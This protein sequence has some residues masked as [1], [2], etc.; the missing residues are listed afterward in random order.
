MEKMFTK[1]NFK[2]IVLVFLLSAFVMM[3]IHNIKMDVYIKYFIIPIM[4]LIGSF[5]YLLHKFKL[6]NN[7][8]S[9]LLLIPIFLILLNY[10]VVDMCYSNMLLNVLM[11]PSILSIFLFTMTN[12]NYNIDRNVLKNFFRIFPG[13]LFSNLSYLKLIKEKKKEKRKSN[14][15][16]IV[17]GILI[18]FPIVGVIF[19]LLISGDAYFGVFA[20]KVFS[21]IS[22]LFSIDSI[23][24][25]IFIIVIVFIFLFSVFVNILRN[26][27]TKGS[28]KEKKNANNYIVS[29]VLIMVNLVYVLF[30]ISELSKLT[31]NFLNVPEL[32]TY[33][34]YA[35]EGFF[36]LLLVTIINMAII[37]YLNYFTK[38]SKESHL[39]RNLMLLL[40]FFSIILIF[41]SYYRMFLYINRFGFTI[42]RSQ[43]ILFLIMEL[44]LFIIMFRR[45]MN[46]KKNSDGCLLA[47]ILI[48]TYIINLYLC[49]S[50]VIDY[51]NKLFNF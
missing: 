1:N 2:L 25:N 14:I 6:D 21:Y 37:G 10:F 51:I 46:K 35:R 16:Y 33:A 38:A 40:C 28:I 49:N 22:E 23:M 45:T 36:E 24:G 5:G 3:I 30:I 12:D 7:K 42:L 17:L 4:I 8:K 11:V 50:N 47:G 41:N 27:F 34:E 19:S 29:T 26:R 18:G 48:V 15:K 43:V 32:Y 44:I 9:Y 13:H 20:G 31:V 39:V